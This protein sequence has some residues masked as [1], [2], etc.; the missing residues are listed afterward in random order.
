M[1][2][3]QTNADCSA[4]TRKLAMR[5]L[6]GKMFSVSH[7]IFSLVVLQLHLSYFAISPGH[8]PGDKKHST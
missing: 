3:A 2:S 1:I 7:T 5:T 4:A 6:H 8:S